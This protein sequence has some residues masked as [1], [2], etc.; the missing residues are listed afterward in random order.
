MSRSTRNF[1]RGQAAALAALLS[2]APLAGCK[3]AELGGAPPEK[4]TDASDAQ[5]PDR[6]VLQLAAP[7]TVTTRDGA[8]ELTWFPGSGEIPVHE[9]FTVEVDV[10]RADEARTPVLG[11]EVAM[12]CFMPDHGHGM[13]REPRSQE[14]GEG[15]YLVEGFLLHMGGYWTVSISVV[16]QGLAATADDEFTIE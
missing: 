8:Y 1:R 11:A 13:L 9:P 5:V 7:R 16:D 2:C 4:G 3:A 6:Q 12:T 14:L 10:R 15:R